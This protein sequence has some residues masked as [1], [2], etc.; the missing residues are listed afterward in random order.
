M[1]EKCFVDTNVFQHFIQLLSSLVMI[2]PIK[3]A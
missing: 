1:I 3:R 2:V